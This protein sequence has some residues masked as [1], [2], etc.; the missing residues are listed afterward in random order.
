M[1]GRSAAEFCSVKGKAIVGGRGGLSGRST[2]VVP[3][4]GG[5]E[6]GS[7]AVENGRFGKGLAAVAVTAASSTSVPP[8]ESSR[9][10]GRERMRQVDGSGLARLAV[11]ASAS[12]PLATAKSERSSPV[13]AASCRT[14]RDASGKEC[15]GD[16]VDDRASHD[17]KSGGRSKEMLVGGKEA[18]LS[19]SRVARNLD[20]SEG[21]KRKQGSGKG[22]SLSSSAPSGAV[23]QAEPKAGTVRATVGSEH[24]NSRSSGKSLADGVRGGVEAPGDERHERCRVPSTCRDQRAVEGMT[25]P[26]EPVVGA[27]A[28]GDREEGGIRLREG[29]G[30]TGPEYVAKVL[31]PSCVASYLGLSR[32]LFLKSSAWVVRG[33]FCRAPSGCDVVH[34]PFDVCERLDTIIGPVLFPSRE[35]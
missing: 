21:R 4:G 25:L 26:Q 18:S 28:E 13:P 5:S 35:P 32:S 22:S 6:A 30:M 1:T 8:R 12:L 17:N 7:V 15:V 20:G 11:D 14:S 27:A 10:L 2:G 23:G 29:E 33:V 9:D 24:G 19:N 16:D 31:H 34:D 3:C